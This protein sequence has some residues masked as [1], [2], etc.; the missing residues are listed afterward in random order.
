MTIPCPSLL[1]PP[2][3]AFILEAEEVR[4]GRP[5]MSAD[6]QCHNSVNSGNFSLFR[7]N[8]LLGLIDE[9]KANIYVASGGGI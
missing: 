1:D 7:N 6:S 3:C 4:E 2:Q 8:L 5:K 9:R